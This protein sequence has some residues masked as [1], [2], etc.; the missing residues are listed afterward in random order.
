M[1]FLQRVD[2]V[3][4]RHI[5]L[6]FMAFLQRVAS[7]ILRHIHLIFM[8]FLLCVASWEKR[9]TFYLFQS[10]SMAT[11]RGNVASILGTVP[12]MKKLDEIYS[13]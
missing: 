7:G 6:I 3:I 1:A 5:H 13:L 12:N 2:S 4:L 9:S 8:A 11:Q 10:L